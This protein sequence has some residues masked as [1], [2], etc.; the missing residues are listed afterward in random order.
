MTSQKGLALVL[1]LWVLSLLTIMAG[2]FALSMRREASITSGIKNNAQALAVAQSGIALAEMMLLLPDKTKTWRTDGSIYQITGTDTQVRVRLFSESGKIDINKADEKLLKALFSQA[3]TDNE[4]LKI[5]KHDIDPVAAI[6]DWRDSDDL[7]HLNGAEKKQ[8]MEAGLNYSPRNKPL[9][10][11]EELQL[12]LGMNEDLINWLEPLITLYSGQAK[13]NLQFASRELLNVM[14]NL[15]A[16]LIEQYLK[17]RRDTAVQGLPAPPFP[18]NGQ[19]IM[20]SE[21]DKQKA[22][23]SQENADETQ[24][25]TANSNDENGENTG[26]A[27]PVSVGAV[28][29]IAEAVLVDGSSAVIKALVKSADGTTNS[30]FA[31]IAWQRDTDLEK[32]LFDDTMDDLVINDYGEPELN[33]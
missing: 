18:T 32:S 30:P 29:I 20:P 31:V 10:S 26:L 22:A 11:I 25:K 13:A 6:L 19:I 1:V 24:D 14:P 5:S 16:E 15:D 23:T 8:Y 17:L 2:S 3:P 33:N 21:S 28:T 27:E 12:I 9:Q 7:I 4:S